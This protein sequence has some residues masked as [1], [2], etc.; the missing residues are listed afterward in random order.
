VVRLHP[1]VPPRFG[2][3]AP[4]LARRFLADGVGPSDASG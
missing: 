3:D 1:V 4:C 2:G